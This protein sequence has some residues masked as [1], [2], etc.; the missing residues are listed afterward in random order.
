MPWSLRIIHVDVLSDG[1]ATLIVASDGS[2]TRSAL[3]DGGGSG[4]AAENVYQVCL[5]EKLKQL[6]LMVSTH[7]DKDHLEGLKHLLFGNTAMFAKVFI[8]D[9]GEAGQYWGNLGWYQDDSYKRYVAAMQKGPGR[10]RITRQVAADYSKNPPNG[11]HRSDWLVGQELLWWGQS[12]PAGAPTLTCVAANQWVFQQGAQPLFCPTSLIKEDNPNAQSLALLLEFGNFRYYVGGDLEQPQEDELIKQIPSPVQVMKASHHGSEYSSSADFLNWLKP[13]AVVVSC[14]T[15][16]RHGHPPQTVIDRLKKNN[17]YLTGENLSDGPDLY[18]P[19]QEV[20]G[21]WVPGTKAPDKLG[22]IT[23]SLS[24]ADAAL[25]KPAFDLQ[26]Y[27]PK[28]GT[29]YQKRDDFPYRPS[30]L[31][32]W[33]FN[34]GGT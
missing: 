18:V 3:I 31:Q 19:D 24:Q 29:N 5:A 4:N 20:A 25:S 11:Y 2:T 10:T 22:T 26:F 14:G 27:R 23:V 1:D 34:R 33:E 16:N 6:D 17:V 13:D 30:K 8:Y 9:R 28:A 7:Y 12:V 32:T 15:D 21:V